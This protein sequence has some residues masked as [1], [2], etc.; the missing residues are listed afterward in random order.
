MDAKYP[1]GGVIEID[2]INTA[3]EGVANATVRFD[4]YVTVASQL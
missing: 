3:G 2:E 4:G 1:L